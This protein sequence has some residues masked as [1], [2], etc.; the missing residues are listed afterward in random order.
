MTP[1]E[2]LFKRVGTAQSHC[3]YCPLGP[4]E[5]CMLSCQKR[6]EDVQKERESDGVKVDDEP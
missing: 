4:N 6:Y 2:Y 5:R 3:T 1:R